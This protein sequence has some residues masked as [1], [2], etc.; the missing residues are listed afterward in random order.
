MLQALV[1]FVGTELAAF[2]ITAFAIVNIV[3]VIITLVIV[4]GIYR[5]HKRLTADLPSE[6]AA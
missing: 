6:Q 1:V 5:E 2:S 4:M 3:F